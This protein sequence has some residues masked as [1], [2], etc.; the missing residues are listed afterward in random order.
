MGLCWNWHIKAEVLHACQLSTTD[1]LPLLLLLLP[2]PVRCGCLSQWT[3]AEKNRTHCEPH[4]GRFQVDN[5]ASRTA[6]EETLPT[7]LASKQVGLRY[8]ETRGG[9]GQTPGSRKASAG[10]DELHRS[11]RC[12]RLP[13][14]ASV[15]TA[16][17]A[18]LPQLALPT[19]SKSEDIAG[20]FRPSR[21]TSSALR[22]GPCQPVQLTI[23]QWSPQKSAIDW[24]LVIPEL[25]GS[26]IVGR[27]PIASH[28]RAFYE[29]P[30][31]SGQGGLVEAAATVKERPG[32]D[33]P[34]ATS[35]NPCIVHR[36]VDRPAN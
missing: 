6:I 34:K 10:R 18:R 5:T 24:R 3:T 36:L 31:I 21:R 9:S 25:L 2:E 13:F 20:Q 26:R 19:Q 32:R 22:R 12:H 11:Q 15:S 16:Q 28:L 33:T 8:G 17:S 30:I 23:I 14:L 4:R 27:S 29:A 7:A 35:W 1:I